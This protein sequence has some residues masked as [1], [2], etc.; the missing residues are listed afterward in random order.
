MTLDIPLITT[1]VACLPE[2]VPDGFGLRVLSCDAPELA[3]KILTLASDPLLREQLSK[4]GNE[5]VHSWTSL[6]ENNHA[7]CKLV[8]ENEK[9]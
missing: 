3:E 9:C 5:Y 8:E 4:K 2:M 1:N 7:W 6:S